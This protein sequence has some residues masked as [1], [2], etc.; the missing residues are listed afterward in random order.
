MQ[1]KVLGKHGI[2]VRESNY[3]RIVD[4]LCSMS[5]DDVFHMDI[6]NYFQI[7][8]EGILIQVNQFLH[9]HKCLKVS[10]SLRLQL[11]KVTGNE[12]AISDKALLRT[13]T[14][15]IMRGTNLHEWFESQIVECER[16]YEEFEP[17]GRNWTLSKLIECE[18][19]LSKYTTLVRW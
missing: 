12:N 17:V 4:I 8:K 10:T 2:I 7:F 5:E 18:I 16:Q 9:L 15:V 3:R 14:E 19:H 1:D 13:K 6:R 11:M